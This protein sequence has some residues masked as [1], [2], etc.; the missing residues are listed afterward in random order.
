MVTIDTNNISELRFKII[1]KMSSVCSNEHTMRCL[2]HPHHLQHATVS[3]LSQLSHSRRSAFPDLLIPQH[4]DPGRPRY[5]RTRSLAVSGGV[6]FVC[7]GLGP[8]QCDR[9]VCPGNGEPAVI[10]Y[11]PLLRHIFHRIFRT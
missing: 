1:A 2:F 4:I 10:F 6:C 5:P 3:Q 9:S 7:F 11:I 8:V